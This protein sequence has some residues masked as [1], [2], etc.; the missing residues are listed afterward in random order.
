MLK[1]GGFNLAKW[2]SSNL[3]LLQDTDSP[4]N[5]LQ[6]SQAPIFIQG[7]PIRKETE[8]LTNSL[9]LN[10]LSVTKS[11]RTTG[12]GGSH[13][14]FPCADLDLCQQN[15]P[16]PTSATASGSGEC[17]LKDSTA[18]VM[19][20]PEAR[21]DMQVCAIGRLVGP[22]SVIPAGQKSATDQGWECS[23]PLSALPTDRQRPTTSTVSES[24]T[25]WGD[26]GSG[27]SAGVPQAG[28]SAGALNPYCPRPS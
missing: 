21:A 19:P 6:V 2:R 20:H 24:A 17:P 26:S 8:P 18:V 1:K 14:S 9:E 11:A 15:C 7:W 4:T 13:D 5:L 3:A 10:L 16:N 23:P 28:D 22:V 25:V 12:H 27:D